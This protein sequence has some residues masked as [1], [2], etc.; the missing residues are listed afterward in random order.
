M[1]LVDIKDVDVCGLLNDSSG[2]SRIISMLKDLL[3]SKGKLPEKCPILKGSQFTFNNVNMDPTSFP[4]LPE[5][6]FKVVMMFSLNSVP[7]S[8]SV[9]VTGNIVNRRRG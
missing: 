9:N 6:N 3:A 7:N 8:F 1:L 4:F 2:S 5:M